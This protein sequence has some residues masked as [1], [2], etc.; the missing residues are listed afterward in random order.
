MPTPFWNWRRSIA[1]TAAAEP[2]ETPRPLEQVELY[3]QDSQVLGLV[4][5][6]GERMSDILNRE[7]ALLVHATQRTP[8]T[9]A[10]VPAESLDVASF[11]MADILLA[12]PPAQTTHPGRRIH[13]KRRRVLLRVGP[14]FVIGTAHLPPGTDLDPYVLRTRAGFVAVTE[15]LVRY[16][17]EPIFERGASVVLVNT[18]AMT[19]AEDLLTVE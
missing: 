14:F 1:A 5:P 15:A 3:T 7:S 8:F 4:A 18:S 19:N 6:D 10:N 9:A 13:R 17:G 11:S 12:M 2:F 16:T